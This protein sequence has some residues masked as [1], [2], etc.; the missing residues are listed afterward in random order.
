MG[1]GLVEEVLP[2]SGSFGLGA[3]APSS[4]RS[5]PSVSDTYEFIFPMIRTPCSASDGLLSEPPV[6]FPGRP[7]EIPKAVLPPCRRSR[8]FWFRTF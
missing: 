1:W 5:A 3:L 8:G 7:P 6:M 4:L 2:G